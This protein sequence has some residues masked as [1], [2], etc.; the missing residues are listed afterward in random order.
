TCGCVKALEGEVLALKEE[1]EQ[2]RQHRRVVDV[3]LEA[4]T[5]RAARLDEELGDS[6]DMRR[7]EGRKAAEENRHLEDMIDKL[8][9]ITLVQQKWI[10]RQGF[11]GSRGRHA[12]VQ[13][14]KAR[15]SHSSSMDTLDN[16]ISHVERRS[17]EQ[18]K[19]SGS[20]GASMGGGHHRSSSEA[21]HLTEKKKG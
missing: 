4:L 1:L 9:E 2:E 16:N 10:S 15:G 13:Q 12:L 20:S 8:E 7:R 3:T 6:E 11:P 19:G 14:Q 18:P 21:K 17:K 5:K